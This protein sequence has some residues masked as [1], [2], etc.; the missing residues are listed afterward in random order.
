MT[1]FCFSNTILNFVA[2]KF[3]T[4]PMW[5]QLL[6]RHP[7]NVGRR[8][9]PPK[10]TEGINKSLV[11]NTFVCDIHKVIKNMTLYSPS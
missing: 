2:W 11:D 8:A 1:F 3:T 6:G 9:P 4:T 10:A 7:Q 5:V